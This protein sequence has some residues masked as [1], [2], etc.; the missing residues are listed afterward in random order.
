[1]STLVAVRRR[2]AAGR[3]F[4]VAV[5]CGDALTGLAL[6]AVPRG[7]LAPLA[8][9]V[10]ADGDFAFR[11]V[12]VFVACVGLAYLYPFALPPARRGVRLA[13]A[14]EWTAGVRLAVAT[15]LA[16]A[17]VAGCPSGWLIVGFFDAAVALAQLRLCAGGCFDAA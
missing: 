14:I 3:F 2:R 9:D 7:V 1:M 17:V 15:F 12:G 16:V 6:V 5:G 13:A 8:L 10:P 4:A 11:F